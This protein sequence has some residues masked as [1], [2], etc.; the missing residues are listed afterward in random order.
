MKYLRLISLILMLTIMVIAANSCSSYCRVEPAGTAADEWADP[1]EGKDCVPK[2]SLKVAV[3]DDTQKNKADLEIWIEGTGS[4]YPNLGFGADYLIPTEPFSE[5]I[6]K[7]YIYPDGR[8][9]NQVVL[10][11]IITDKMTPVSDMDTIHIEIHDQMVKA[12]GTPVKD[13]LQEFPR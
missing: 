10:D 12:W 11:I 7:I 6:N 3:Y 9:G 5:D 1:M 13:S 8:G 4:W 2:I